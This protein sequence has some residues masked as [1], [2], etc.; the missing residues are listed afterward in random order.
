M[1]ECIEHSGYVENSGYSKTS[2]EGR[3]GYAHRKA[4]AEKAGL[5]RE[6]LDG[7]VVRHTCDNKR[8]VN[9]DHL[10]AGTH[11]DNMADRKKAGIKYKKLA[12]DDVAAIRSRLAEGHTLV[13]IAKDYGVSKQ[14][15]SQIKREVT[16]Q[17][18]HT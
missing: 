8:C 16:W 13:A 6:Q 5:S 14:T 18:T 11:K 10:E 7:V 17:P 2:W 9:P 4:Y 12:V 3:N 15:I 1:S